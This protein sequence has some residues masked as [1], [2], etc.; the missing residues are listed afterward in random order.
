MISIQKTS[1]KLVLW[2]VVT[3]LLVGIANVDLGTCATTTAQVVQVAMGLGGIWAV[4]QTAAF[5]RATEG[6]S[7]AAS[8]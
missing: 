2:S 8:H 5:A 1:R 6:L 4:A 7:G 3:W